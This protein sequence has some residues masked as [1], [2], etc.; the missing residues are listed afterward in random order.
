MKED[1]F[2]ELHPAVNLIHILLVLAFTMTLRHPAAQLISF[3]CALFR[4]AFGGEKKRV[5]FVLV[6]GIPAAAL[7][8]VINA[9]FNRAGETVLFRFPSGAG[10]TLEST[11]YGVSSGVML[12]TVL[13]IFAAVGRTFNDE[14]I[15]A[16]F[17]RRFPSLALLL[18]MTFRAVPSF[19]GRVTELNALRR[20]TKKSI[21]DGSLRQRMRNGAEILSAVMRISLESVSLTAE[22]MNSRGYGLEGRTFFAQY[23]FSVRDAAALFGV[24]TFGAAV[25]AF[26]VSG[27]FSFEFFPC[28][29]KLHFD[30]LGFVPCAAYTALCIF[31][32]AYNLTEVIRWTVSRSKI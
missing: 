23:R 19:I 28:L 9:L 10:V 7:A 15:T 25:F 20:P 16:L 32:A 24:L 12:I 14:R 2:G 1:R 4:L 8:A 27:G 3:L 29:T 5:L 21:T 6:G 22:S 31:P 17:G 26:A 11:L 18:S 30:A 13:A